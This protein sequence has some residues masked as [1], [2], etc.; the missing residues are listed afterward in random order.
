MVELIEEV[1]LVAVR[2]SAYTV[3]VFQNTSTKKYIMCT[4][5]PNWQVPS[6]SPGDEGFLKYSIV[7]AGE[8]YFNVKDNTT[9]KFLYSNVYFNNFILKTEILKNN[10]LIL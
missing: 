8:S 1:K 5:L 2:E 4:R 3:Y 10:E 9:S 6:I 7:Q